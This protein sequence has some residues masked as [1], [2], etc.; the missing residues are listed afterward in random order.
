MGLIMVSDSSVKLLQIVL[1]I[2]APVFL[3]VSALHLWL[4][5]GAEVL[6]WLRRVHGH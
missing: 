5:L 6:L 2:I 1:K 4:G 3:L